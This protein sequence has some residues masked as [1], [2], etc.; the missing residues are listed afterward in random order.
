MV[1]DVSN[2]PLMKPGARNLISDVPGIR[3]GNAHNKLI[4]TGCTV[5]TAEHPFV[6]AVDVMGGAPGSR[7]TDCL[8]PERLVTAV[9]A[10]VLSG[11]SAFGLDAASGVT[12]ALRAAGKGFAV[13]PV[14]VP[15]VPSAI[16]FDLLNGGDKNWQENPYQ[17]LGVEAFTALSR[18][19]ELGTIGAG[20]GATCAT[21]KGGLGSASLVLPS[22]YTVGALVVA[23][24]HGSAVA[25]GSQQFWAA[26]FE[27]D[28]E[29]GGLGAVTESYGLRMP[30]NEKLAAYEALANTTL[31]IVATDARLNKAQAKRLAVAGQDGIARAVVPA[32]T[33]YDGDLVFGM[34]TGTQ[35]L[36]DAQQD[37]VTLGHAASVCVARAIAR[38]VFNA[39]PEKGDILP[40][41]RQKFNP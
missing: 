11:G 32:H 19:F 40:T 25:P 18:N 27:V 41:W 39:S 1:V 12:N 30:G 5:V 37:L 21:L 10:L 13:G 6:A 29:F 34:S 4:K 35:P 9:N 31:A 16:I 26:P 2:T 23:N 20:Y 36:I 38:A 28:N 15:I 8:D 22:G 7:E 33:Q 14:T 17:A 24:P 3:V